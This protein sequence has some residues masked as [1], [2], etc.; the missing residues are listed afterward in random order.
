LDE[1][2][3]WDDVTTFD[4]HQWRG[5]VDCIV[6]GF[7][8]QDV[9]NAGKRA[10]LREGKRSGLWSEFAR[11]IG[12]VGPSYVFVENVAAL[13][14]RGLDVVLGDLADLGFDAEWDVFTAAEVGA[15]HQRRRLFILGHAVGKGLEVWEGERGDADTECPTAERAGAVADSSIVGDDDGRRQQLEEGCSRSWDHGEWLVEPDVGRV[16]DGVPHRVDRLRC[17]GNAVVPA[18]AALAWSTLYRRLMG[19]Q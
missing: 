2:P 6:G 3:I 8:C 4:G 5:A 12:E 11:I 16:A 13:A 19:C 9:S 17:L 1:A 15:P 18:T 10:G 14:K 7:P